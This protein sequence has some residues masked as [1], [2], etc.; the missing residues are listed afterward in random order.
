MFFGCFRKIGGWRIMLGDVC[1]G[2]CESWFDVEVE[3]TQKNEKRMEKD[4][5]FMKNYNITIIITI[6]N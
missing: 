6:I 3:V 2:S 4:N 1:G 5:G